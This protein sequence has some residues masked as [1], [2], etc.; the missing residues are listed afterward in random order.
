MSAFHRRPA[1]LIL[2]LSLILCLSACGSSQV[3]P[4]PTAAVS[5]MPTAAP[6]RAEMTQRLIKILEENPNVKNLLQK[7][8]DAAKKINP[9][10]L[11]NPAQS[12]EEYYDYID[13]ACTAMPWNIS[14]NVKAE[15]LYEKIDQSLN[16]FY[17]INDQPLDELEGQG[18]YNNSLQY[19][20]PYRSWLIEF[21]RAWGEYLST[22]V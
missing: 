11:T 4:T 15:G 21:T 1:A 7:S 3:T 20:E 5:S 6:A 9:D 12:L 19:A 22:P 14:K 18:L 16:Y 2:S 17:F 10:P 13:W 8:I